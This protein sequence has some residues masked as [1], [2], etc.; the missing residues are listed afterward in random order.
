MLAYQLRLIPRQT[1]GIAITTQAPQIKLND[2]DKDIVTATQNPI[3]GTLHTI[4]D[5]VVAMLACH[6]NDYSPFKK[7]Q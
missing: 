5:T 6:K 7:L 3:K 2:R 1:S 4:S